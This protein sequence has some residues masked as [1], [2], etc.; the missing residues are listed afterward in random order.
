[1]AVDYVKEELAEVNA[2]YENSYRVSVRQKIAQIVSQ[3]KIVDDSMKLL[4]KLK[5]EL[6]ELSY[7]PIDATVLE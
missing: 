1:M 7:T 5:V 6:K 3:Q 2:Q 4:A